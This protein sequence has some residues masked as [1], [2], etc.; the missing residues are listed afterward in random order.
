LR[1][2]AITRYEE[3][4]MRKILLLFVCA[5]LATACWAQPTPKKTMHPSAGVTKKMLND[6]FD[7]WST[8]DTAKI[9]P[10]YS[11]AP[12]NLYFDVMPMQYRGWADWA[13]GVSQFF[14]G[15]K[16]FKLTIVGDPS[17]HNMGNSAWTALLWHIDAVNKSG[18]PE[19]FDGRGTMIWQ[20]QGGKWLIVHEHDSVPMAAPE[21]P[22][23]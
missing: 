23:Q 16:T 2:Q 3:I 13:K 4:F 21:A 15:Y 10:Y 18:K 7:A 22:K 6:I 12:Q 8:M 9:A 5:C 20:K 11:Q 1:I 19:T 14:S 17:I